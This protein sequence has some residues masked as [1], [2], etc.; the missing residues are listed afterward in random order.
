MSGGSASKGLSHEKVRGE[1]RQEAVRMILGER[2]LIVLNSEDLLY[3]LVKEMSV[4]SC[5]DSAKI[6]QIDD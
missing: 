4:K 5:V 2:W 6:D 1:S 3:L